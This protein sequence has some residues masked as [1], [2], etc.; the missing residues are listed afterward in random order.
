MKIPNIDKKKINFEVNKEKRTVCCYMKSHYANEYAQ[1]VKSRILGNK[2]VDIND[3][4]YFDFFLFPERHWHNT[5]SGIAKCSPNDEWNEEIGKRVAFL[6][7]KNKILKALATKAA[8][9]GKAY[10]DKASSMFSIAFVSFVN[11][12]KNKH[13][14]H[15]GE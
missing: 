10:I 9:V 6:K 1:E 14:I 7:L 8:E 11:V 15:E 2:Y 4:N 5:I 13:S 3:S 12:Q